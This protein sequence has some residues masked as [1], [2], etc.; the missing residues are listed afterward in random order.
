MADE[1]EQFPRFISTKQSPNNDVT[2][3]MLHEQ[4]VNNLRYILLENGPSQYANFDDA[5]MSIIIKGVML[6]PRKMPSFS[7]LLKKL[8]IRIV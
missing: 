4:N 6:E 1:T 5:R 8:R 7:T 2:P 3:P